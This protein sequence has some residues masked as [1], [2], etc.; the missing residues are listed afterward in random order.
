MEFF[1][2]ELS[3]IP[4]KRDEVIKA[5]NIQ[6]PL[7]LLIFIFITMKIF[8]RPVLIKQQRA[9]IQKNKFILK[10]YPLKS[11]NGD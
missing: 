1:G 6:S 2:I 5:K 11:R 10:T 3:G 4:E 9:K 8:Y 7:A